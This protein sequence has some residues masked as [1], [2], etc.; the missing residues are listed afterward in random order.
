MTDIRKR[1]GRDGDVTYQVRFRG[2]NGYEYR[3]FE[4]AKE[5]RAFRE[6]SSAQKRAVRRGSEVV[7]VAQGVQKWLDIC[8]KEGRNGREPVTRYTLDN[9]EYPC[10]LLSPSAL[11]WAVGGG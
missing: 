6:D 5:A 4:T 8:D 3:T 9:Y 11:C 10:W 2:A 7:T 1:V